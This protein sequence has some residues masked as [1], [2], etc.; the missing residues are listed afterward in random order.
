MVYL[1]L[2]KNQ[3]FLHY[4]DRL[5]LV[6][7]LVFYPFKWCVGWLV[8]HPPHILSSDFLI[9]DSSKF[10]LS[11]LWDFHS[12]LVLLIL[13]YTFHLLNGRM[14]HISLNQ[15]FLLKWLFHTCFWFFCFVSFCNS[16]SFSFKLFCYFFHFVDRRKTT[17][18]HFRNL[19][20]TIT[21]IKIL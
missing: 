1:F 7:T 5:I 9:V 17:I 19:S 14:V 16:Y 11:F 21:I 12:N 10:L 8:L 2:C 15:S 4:F 13:R 6:F 18:S 3:I 20:H